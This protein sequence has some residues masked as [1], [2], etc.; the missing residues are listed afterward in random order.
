ML[1]QRITPDQVL[2]MPGVPGVE[3]ELDRPPFTKYDWDGSRMLARAT[4]NPVT[5][6][7]YGLGGVLYAPPKTVVGGQLEPLSFGANER[8]S[9]A[10]GATSLM[11]GVPTGAGGGSF[12]VR[13]ADHKTDTAV[14]LYHKQQAVRMAKLA[15][16][17]TLPNVALDDGN[18]NT[19]WFIA[20][21]VRV[22][23]LN[24]TTSPLRFLRIGAAAGYFS[25]GYEG[26]AAANPNCL[27][28]TSPNA[29]G[30][31]L[32]AVR[33]NS[34][35][36]PQ[37]APFGAT[38]AGKY[39]WVIVIK[40]ND[41]G[42][43]ENYLSPST[44]LATATVRAGNSITLAYCPDLAPDAAGTLV[45][46]GS[47]NIPKANFSGVAATPIIIGPDL[48]TTGAF[49]VSDVVIAHQ[50][51]TQA[52]IVELAKGKRWQDIGGTVAAGT[53]RAYEFISLTAAE[54]LDR[55]GG[56]AATSVTMT[57]GDGL[58]PASDLALTLQYAGN[59]GATKLDGW[60]LDGTGYP[61]VLA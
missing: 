48:D 35:P 11:V 16:N 27:R 8:L 21:R 1:S 26:S 10:G 50:M 23:A 9:A 39:M 6:E 38:F 43:T 18:S 4:I 17:I 57:G 55:C 22:A 13:N 37:F 12:R 31:G 41:V 52:Q 33:S 7:L 24:T 30:T 45:Y 46:G 28:V 54:I 51:P 14:Y 44:G 5:G 60:F 15:S 25:I 29:A 56:A 40:T 20:M 19:A 49:D 47:V 36:E 3:Y 61:D 34:S 2:R 42:I 53:D 58:T 59:T 32:S